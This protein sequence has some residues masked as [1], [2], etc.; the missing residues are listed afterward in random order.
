M[1]SC[2]KCSRKVK[3]SSLYVRSNGAMSIM[4]KCRKHGLSEG[5]FDTMD[6]VFEKGFGVKPM[7]EKGSK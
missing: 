1:I 3:F 6:E 7:K 5:D 4:V 2:S